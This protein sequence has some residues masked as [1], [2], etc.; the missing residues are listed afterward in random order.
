MRVTV[1]S[2]SSNSLSR[3]GRGLGRGVKKGG[4]TER[5]PM[6]GVETVLAAETGRPAGAAQEF[7]PRRA[8]G[9]RAPSGAQCLLASGQQSHR[10]RIRPTDIL[11]VPALMSSLAGI[12]FLIW[13]R[14][15]NDIVAAF[16]RIL[17]GTI[18]L[19]SQLPLMISAG[20]GCRQSGSPASVP[21][22]NREAE[23]A[24]RVGH[25][26]DDDPG[27][28]PT[29]GR[30]HGSEVCA[31]QPAP[32]GYWPMRIW[33]RPRDTRTWPTTSVFA[34]LLLILFAGDDSWNPRRHRHRH[35]GGSP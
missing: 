23:C 31:K 9:V 19:L 17:S 24:R 35:L 18:G 4:G 10:P 22:Q 11:L 16:F 20:L 28:A 27:H 32:A 14:L 21:P 12:A 26:A 6:R 1:Q 8:T 13:P 15:L 30:G 3:N 25:P 7:P 33:V 5:L 34:W 2:P 29:S